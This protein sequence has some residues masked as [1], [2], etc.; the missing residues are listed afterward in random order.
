MRRGLA[1]RSGW[2]RV[3]SSRWVETDG[4]AERGAALEDG[5]GPRR[6]TVVCVL[7]MSRSGTSLTARILNLGGMYLGPEEGLLSSRPSNPDGHF[8]NAAMMRFNEWLLWSLG[9][10]WRTPPTMPVGWEQSETLAAERRMARAF[11]AETF[12][13]H[14]LWGWKDPRNCLTLPFWQCLVPE[15]RYV[16]CLRNPI[17][18]AASLERR[19]GMEAGE[20][21]ALWLVYVKAA[22]AHTE[23]QPRIVVSY[24]DYFDER[25]SP[26]ARLID[27]VGAE[28]AVGGSFLSRTDETIKEDLRHHSTPAE[29]VFDDGRVPAEVASLYARV[30]ELA[31]EPEPQLVNG[32]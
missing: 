8:E 28:Q 7:G 32:P 5:M 12:G 16:V 31:V 14:E 11:L 19:N 27:F 20:A 10:N 25:R 24:E 17:D 9:G 3:S 22:L 29:A 1:N 21:F 23:G 4:V 6:L 26:V 13:G 2:I 15:M 18:I 30:R